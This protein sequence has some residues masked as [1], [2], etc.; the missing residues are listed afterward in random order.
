MPLNI[1]TEDLTF[2]Q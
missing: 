2:L 1:K